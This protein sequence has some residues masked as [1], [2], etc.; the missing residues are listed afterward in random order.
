MR[1]D[2]TSWNILKC[3]AYF[4]DCLYLHY[5]KITH[6]LHTYVAGFCFGSK[7]SQDARCLVRNGFGLEVESETIYQPE[8][9]FDY[10]RTIFLPNFAE[11]HALDG[12]TEEMTVL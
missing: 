1:L 11:L 10:I 2:D 7:A 6:P 3:Q 4:G 12:F 9:L 8:N 5:W